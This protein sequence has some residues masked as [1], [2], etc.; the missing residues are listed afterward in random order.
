MDITRY[1]SDYE[2]EKDRVNR[3]G[4]VH[5]C[6]INNR[7]VNI[8]TISNDFGAD[9]LV[10]GEL[11]RDLAIARKLYSYTILENHLEGTRIYY[12]IHLEPIPILT[13]LVNFLLRPFLR[14]RLKKSFELLKEYCEQTK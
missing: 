8:E 13:W 14:N 1:A 2:Y 5:E 9:K 3:V 11:A 12:E 4:F 10:Y 7:K 6:V